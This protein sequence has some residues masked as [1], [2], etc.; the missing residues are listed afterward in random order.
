MNKKNLIVKQEVCVQNVPYTLNN[1][2]SH[3]LRNVYL[4]M[5][6]FNKTYIHYELSLSI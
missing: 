4:S 3:Q 2:R 6:G 5:I 1:E